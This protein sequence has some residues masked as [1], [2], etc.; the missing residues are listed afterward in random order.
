[1]PKATEFARTALAMLLFLAPP[2]SVGQKNN[3]DTTGNPGQPFTAIHASLLTAADNAIEATAPRSSDQNSI[4]HSQHALPDSLPQPLKGTSPSGWTRSEGLDALVQPILAREGVPSQLAAVIRVESRGNPLALSSK[5]AR[6][7]WQ[8]MPDTARRYGLTVNAHMDERVD[9]EKSTT[10]A[11]RYLRDL[12][13]QFGSW[14]LA[15]AAYNTGERNLEGAIDRGRSR[16]FATLSFLGYL[17]AETRSYVPAV[18]AA[19][20]ADGFAS[21]SST[22]SPSSSRLVFAI[23]REP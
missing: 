21:L 22:R 5:G 4:D 16:D 11:A 18:L 2:L 17:P 6:G 7:L 12:Y 15:L 10:G 1:M 19:M 8:L 20:S 9:I 3:A 13:V 23:P 14:Q